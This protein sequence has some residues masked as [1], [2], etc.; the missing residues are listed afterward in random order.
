[1]LSQTTVLC[2]SPL[3]GQVQATPENAELNLQLVPQSTLMDEFQ[4][5]LDIYF[6]ALFLLR[7]RI[8]ERK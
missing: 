5:L 2:S 4:L 6:L 8:A 7:L 3:P 1:M